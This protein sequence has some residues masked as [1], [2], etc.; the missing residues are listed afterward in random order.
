MI[1]KKYR[2]EKVSDY[3]RR[4]PRIHYISFKRYL[5]KEIKINTKCEHCKLTKGCFSTC[6]MNFSPYVLQNY[7]YIPDKEEIDIT[8]A[9]S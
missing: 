8:P 5:R 3:F 1:V 6:K 2:L 9:L 7:M 4:I